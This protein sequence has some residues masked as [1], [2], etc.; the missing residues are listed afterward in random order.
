MS[1]SQIIN[2]FTYKLPKHLARPMYSEFTSRFSESMRLI[3]GYPKYT[4]L[5]D[6]LETVEL[7]L[8]LS[9]FTNK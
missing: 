1:T 7:L 2:I 5:K 8:A 4:I 6:D 9:I 3:E